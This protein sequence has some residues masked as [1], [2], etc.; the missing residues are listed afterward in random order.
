MDLTN[1]T[2]IEVE[3]IID[4]VKRKESTYFLDH[5]KLELIHNIL[6]K[7]NIEHYIFYPYN[8]ATYGM[9]HTNKIVNV[10]LLKINSTHT[11]THPSIMGSLYQ[12][13]LK[14]EIFGD[15][16]I[17]NNC[18]Y[19]VVM[20]HMAEYIINNIYEIGSARVILEECDLKEIEEYKPAFKIIT[21]TVTSE[22]LDVVI[23]KIIGTS[24]NIVD[25]KFKNKEIILNYEIATKPSYLLKE[26]DIFSIRKNGKYK[27][28]GVISKSKKDK[29]V[30]QYQKYIN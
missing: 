27:Y 23:A 2:K 30:I 4:K 17:T 14:K 5:K 3:S 24:R 1:Q 18:Y 22:R 7:Q 28:L 20:K 13:N 19:V 10:S 29:Y 26:D 11:L 8:G 9:I 15:I 16:I 6:K 21:T 12:L 25:E